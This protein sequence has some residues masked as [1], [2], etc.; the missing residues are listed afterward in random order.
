MLTSKYGNNNVKKL[1]LIH[2]E[3]WELYVIVV[4][5]SAL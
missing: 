3:G 2:E 5:M 1:D 4:I